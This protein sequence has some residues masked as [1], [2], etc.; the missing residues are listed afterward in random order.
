MANMRAGV[1]RSLVGALRT[2][3]TGCILTLLAIRASAQIPVGAGSQ[4]CDQYLQARQGKSPENATR[5]SM[6]VSWVQ[7]YLVGSAQ[8]ITGERIAPEIAD[9]ITRG[10]LPPDLDLVFSDPQGRLLAMLQAKFGTRSGWV[11]DPPDAK[12]IEAWLANY[13]RDHPAN[14]ISQAAETLATELQERAK[15]K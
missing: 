15:R 6:I 14:R 10:E 3:V 5:R 13:C 1:T 7:G 8:M 11:F 4:L 2:V 12:K 9:R